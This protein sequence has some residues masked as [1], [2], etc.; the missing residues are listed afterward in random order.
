M[1]VKV[2]WGVRS[3]LSMP[4]RP[5]NRSTWS[6][7]WTVL[8][9][10]F[11]PLTSNCSPSITHFTIFCFRLKQSLFFPLFGTKILD[12]CAWKKKRIWESPQQLIKICLEI[13]LE[14]LFFCFSSTKQCQ[15]STQIFVMSA[16]FIRFFRYSAPNIQVYHIFCNFLTN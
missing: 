1:L 8:E 13:K 3:R 2:T 14:W 10:S 7:A 16:D 9:F 15:L 11:F 6:A 12:D 5:L 4:L